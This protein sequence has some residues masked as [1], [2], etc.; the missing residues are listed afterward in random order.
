[1]KTKLPLR[2]DY[3]LIRR[4]ILQSAKKD[5]SVSPTDR[6]MEKVVKAF[7]H[8][9]GSWE[10]LFK[11]ST[12]EMTLLKKIIKIGV[13]KNLFTPSPSWEHKD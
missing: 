4:F 5:G 6:D 2:S 11:G 9:G 3:R 13:K 1:M 10:K 12:N 7:R 8:F